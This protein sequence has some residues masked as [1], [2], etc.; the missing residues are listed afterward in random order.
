[1]YA[2]A[3]CPDFRFVATSLIPLCDRSVWRETVSVSW[4][5]YDHFVDTLTTKRSALSF[6]PEEMDY[7]SL[8]TAAR[9]CKGCDLYKTATQ[10]VFG[11]GQKGAKAMLIGEQP[12][13]E[14]DK[15]GHPFVG[16]AGKLLDRALVNAGIDRAAIYVTNAVKHFKWKPVGKRRLHE[17]PKAGEINA[18]RPWLTAEIEGLKP[19]IIVC[20][21]ATAAQTLR[22]PTFRVTQTRGRWF[23]YENG[24]KL[25]ATIHP[26]A[27]LRT[28]DVK[29]EADY[30]H[31]VADLTLVAEAIAKLD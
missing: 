5:F 2:G 31:F 20:L 6:L 8:R 18:C 3:H 29:R 1:M 10:T 9:N 30:R 21:G 23:D 11:E 19:K 15:Q 12:G 24:E 7:L 4:F 17:K 14:E 22:G 25:I 26:S 27:I 28:P 13:D 16:P